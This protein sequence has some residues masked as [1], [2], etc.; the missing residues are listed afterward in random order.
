[1]KLTLNKDQ[2]ELA[3]RAREQARE[4]ARRHVIEAKRRLC[5]RGRASA[6]VDGRFV[7]PIEGRTDRRGSK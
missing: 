1:M 5:Q 7:Q 4:V 2:Y 6:Y 3:A